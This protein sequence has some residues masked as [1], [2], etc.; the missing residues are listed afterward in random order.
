MKVGRQRKVLEI[1]RRRR[2]ATQEELSGELKKNGYNVTQATISRDIKELGL[3]KIP[4]DNNELYYARPGENPVPTSKERLRKVF[5]DSVI[6]FDASENLIILKT[7]PGGAQGVASAID[8]SGWEEIIGTVGGDD[9]I[10]VVVKPKEATGLVLKKF[11][12][13]LGG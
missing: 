13:L 10:L 11:G 2:I 9:T 7:N 5:L 1:I 12:D 3:V 4:F 8:Q 6:G